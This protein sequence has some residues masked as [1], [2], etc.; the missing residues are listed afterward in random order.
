M[1]WVKQQE[2]GMARKRMRNSGLDLAT[3]Q[4]HKQ[5]DICFVTI[6]DDNKNPEIKLFKLLSDFQEMLHQSW[7]VQGDD[8]QKTNQIAVT[9]S[10]GADQEW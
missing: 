7:G 5:L 6:S 10:N 8:W 9:S 1:N 2:E 4:L 3:W